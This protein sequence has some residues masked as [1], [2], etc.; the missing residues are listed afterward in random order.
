MPEVGSSTAHH[1]DGG[2]VSFD[3]VIDVQN[4]SKRFG[5]LLAVNNCSLRVE[6]GS[7]TGLIGPNGAGKSTL[8][9]L[10]A[11]NI[12]PDSGRI[13][14]DGARCHRPEAAPAVP[15]R[16]AAHLPDRARILQHDGAREPDDGARRPAGRE[17][18]HHLVRCRARCRRRERAVRQKALD[19]IDFLKL[20]PCARTSSP[21]TSP[22]ARRSCS[23]SAAP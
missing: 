8:F 11:G 18:A 13:I 22:A 5:G 16:H 17:P 20:G 23:N 14:F 7:I 1:Q 15:P 21:A 19:V 6:R 10:V 12:A 3:A 4:V 2:V 9:N